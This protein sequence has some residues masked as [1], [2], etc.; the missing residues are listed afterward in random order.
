[1]EERSDT[2][3]RTIIIALAAVFILVVL[4]AARI[5]FRQ[6]KAVQALEAAGAQFTSP[7]PTTWLPRW[8]PG[9][10]QARYLRS[11]PPV[12]MVYH[13]AE[14]PLVHVRHV[15]A[16]E[17]LHLSGARISDSTL[18]HVQALSGLQ[19]LD[20]SKTAIGDSGVGHLADLNSLVRLDLSGTNVTDAGLVH[21][22]QFDN[23]EHLCLNETA[24]TDTGL[25]TLSSL[26]QLASLELRNAD[27][28]D[29][30]L[31]H[32]QALSNLA[33]V[34]L[35]GTACGP[36][37]I[38]EL[39]SKLPEALILQSKYKQWKAGTILGAEADEKPPTTS[40]KFEYDPVGRRERTQP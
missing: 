18:K 3:H 8:I 37:G 22:L 11:R 34:N 9:A 32:L 30:G 24:I 15:R 4:G 10:L 28:T 20:L 6:H 13:G 40:A 35:I 31:A 25:Q 5:A 23:L 26:S 29:A 12:R 21:L 19:V 1:M 38:Q 14:E 33:R 27:V 17:E 7:P 36:A 16:L 2:K 39:S